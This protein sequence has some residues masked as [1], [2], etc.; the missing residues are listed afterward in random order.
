VPRPQ[1]RY[2][3]VSVLAIVCSR[4]N[5]YLSIL[6]LGRGAICIFGDSPYSSEEV[7]L[8]IEAGWGGW[9]RPPQRQTE[10]IPAAPFAANAGGPSGGE[11]LA[12]AAGAA[13]SSSR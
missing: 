1:K 7:N 12:A 4:G 11:W 10:R 3:T 6:R 13:A 2:A 8:R 9:R 5:Q